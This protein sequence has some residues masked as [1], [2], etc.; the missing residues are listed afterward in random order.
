MTPQQIER[1]R[2]LE[3]LIAHEVDGGKAT[4]LAQELQQLSTLELDMQ[5][6]IPPEAMPAWPCPACGMNLREHTN[7]MIKGC[8][9]RVKKLRARY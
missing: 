4:L 8:T 9:R 2:E 7:A 3:W 1:L 6:Q 5:S